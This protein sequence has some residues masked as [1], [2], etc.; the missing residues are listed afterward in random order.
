MFTLFTGWDMAVC[1]HLMSNLRLLKNNKNGIFSTQFFI[2]KSLEVFLDHLRHS[3]T[4]IK[5]LKKMPNFCRTSSLTKKGNFILLDLSKSM[6]FHKNQIT[7]MW[8]CDPRHFVLIKLISPCCINNA[9]KIPT[10][11]LPCKN[12]SCRWKIS[13]CTNFIPNGL[14]KSMVV[15]FLCPKQIFQNHNLNLQGYGWSL[16]ES[17][18]LKFHSGCKKIWN[19]WLPSVLGP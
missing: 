10:R 12:E 13:L 14:K 15:F 8:F 1:L 9:L 16:L 19:F 11:W 18:D 4:K 3:E 5:I 7:F 6:I 2:R 17:T